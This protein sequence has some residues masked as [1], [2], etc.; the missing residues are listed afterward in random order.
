MKKED[1]IKFVEKDLGKACVEVLRDFKT[2]PVTASIQE[3]DNGA[4]VFT[5]KMQTLEEKPFEI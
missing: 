5:V 3:Q 4:V 2:G 1:L